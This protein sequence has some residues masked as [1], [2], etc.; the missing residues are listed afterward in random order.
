V[1][2]SHTDDFYSTPFRK[3]KKDPDMFALLPL[4]TLRN[5]ALDLAHTDYVLLVHNARA[6]L[7]PTCFPCYVQADLDFVPNSGLHG[8]LQALLPSLDGIPQV[9]VV[10]PHFESLDCEQPDIPD[11]VQELNRSL[12]AGRIRPFL[13]KTAE[14]IPGYPDSIQTNANNTCFLSQSQFPPG[15]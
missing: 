1:Y 7:T 12:Q 5:L 11:N 2:I 8:A 13:C 4:N 15:R 3:L 6:V 9:A 14:L 10:I